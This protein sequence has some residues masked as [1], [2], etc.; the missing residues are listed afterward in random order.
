MQTRKRIFQSL[1][2]VAVLVTSRTGYPQKPGKVIVPRDKPLQLFNG[3]DLTGL[4]TWLRDAGAKDPRGVFSVQK[5]LLHISGNGFGYLRTTADYRDYHMVVEFKWGSRTWGNRKDRSRDSGVLVHATGP[6]GSGGG[7]WMA[8]IESQI[9][10]GGCGDFIVIGG[11]YAD[12]KPVPSQ[13]TCE[14]TKDRD[15][16]A[17][18]KKGSRRQ[19]FTSGRVNWF[20]RDPDWKDILGFRGK[21]DVEHVYGKWNRMEVT[22]RGDSIQIR[23]NGVLVNEAHKVFPRSGKVLIQTE[24]AEMFVRRWEL[25][26]LDKIPRLGPVKQD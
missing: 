7:T 13:I 11:K 17:V 22:C 2:I 8:S 26:P 1:V 18:W 19:V 4:K 21:R 20:G 25:Y 14:V 5:G 6:D 9:I 16:E 15:G 24:M 10:E 23:I 12:G 3:K